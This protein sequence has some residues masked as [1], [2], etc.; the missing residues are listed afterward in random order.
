MED[1][2]KETEIARK[3]LIRNRAELHEEKK[4][5]ELAQH[6]LDDSDCKVEEYKK[7]FDGRVERLETELGNTRRMLEEERNK[8]QPLERS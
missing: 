4:K 5:F 8:V 1:Y 3:D 2:K 6:K 7:F